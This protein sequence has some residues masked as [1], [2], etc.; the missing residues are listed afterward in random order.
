[1]T[2]KVQFYFVCKMQCTYKLIMFT[3][4]QVT[5]GKFIVG[6]SN[7]MVNFEEVKLYRSMNISL[8]N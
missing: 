1:M 6:M 2:R 8:V 4:T 5:S 7:Q 3:V